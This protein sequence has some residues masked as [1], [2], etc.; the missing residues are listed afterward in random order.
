MKFPKRRTGNFNRASRETSARDQGS[1]ARRTEKVCA[2]R[3][4]DA[5]AALWLAVAH[6]GMKQDHC[7][8]SL[9][10]ENLLAQNFY[11]AGTEI[12]QPDFRVTFFH[13]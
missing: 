11:L 4:A 2:L 6:F 12:T 1:W 13:V 3:N 5:F 8:T 9:L 7:P 10:C